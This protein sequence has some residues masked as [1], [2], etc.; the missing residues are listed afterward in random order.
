MDLMFGERLACEKLCG[1]GR[2][3]LGWGF[4]AD[5][6]CLVLH[7]VPSH[8]YFSHL[9]SGWHCSGTFLSAHSS[10]VLS[11]STP[12][13]GALECL[14]PVFHAATATLPPT[15]SLRAPSG[16]Y[17]AVSR[18][19]ETAKLVPGGGG[20]S[21]KFELRADVEEGD[22]ATRPSGTRWIFKCQKSFVEKAR[23]QADGGGVGKKMSASGGPGRVLDMGQGLEG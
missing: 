15:V 5:L 10:G 6:Y 9:S 18:L 16:T 19:T 12:S 17:L 8:I 7:F 11:A 21:A 14:T 20:A 1:H 2:T 3:A 13:R 4:E 23:Q 22:L